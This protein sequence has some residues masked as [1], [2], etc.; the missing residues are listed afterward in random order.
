MAKLAIAGAP[1][2]PA[3]VTL[4][5]VSS[6][7]R[8]VIAEPPVSAPEVAICELPKMVLLTIETVPPELKIP[9]PWATLSGPVTTSVFPLTVLSAMLRVPL[10][11][12]PAPRTAPLEVSVFSRV[13]P[14]TATPTRER[15]D[16]LRLATAPPWR[17]SIPSPTTC[18][19]EIVIPEIVTW[20]GL[21]TTNACAEV[22]PST[23]T[24]VARAPAPWMF[25]ACVIVRPPRLIG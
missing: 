6:V 20:S 18:P 23:I 13:V 17:K 22:P 19:E 21:A 14:V 12:I 3:T 10:F 5:S 16:P 7:P 11:V 25:W 8:L 24:F 9:A 15:T 2:L 1:A 4:S